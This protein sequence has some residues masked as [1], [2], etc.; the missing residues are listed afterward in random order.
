[1]AKKL[2]NKK[3]IKQAKNILSGGIVVVGGWMVF[4]GIRRGFGL[5]EINPLIS[6]ILGIIIGIFATKIG[7]KQ[8]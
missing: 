8:K 6:I 7:I 2:F 1:M 3:E 4:D 5:T